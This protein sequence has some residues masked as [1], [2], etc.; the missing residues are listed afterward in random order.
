HFRALTGTTA[1]ARS[2]HCRAEVPNNSFLDGKTNKA[3]ISASLV[4]LLYRLQS[5]QRSIVAPLS[6][7]A[8][9][10]LPN[11]DFLFVPDFHGVDLGSQFAFTGGT[12]RTTYHDWPFL[13]PS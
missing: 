7:M 13:N 11:G 10:F 2:L 4:C 3:G 8:C 12:I 9:L 6:L 1:T 5:L